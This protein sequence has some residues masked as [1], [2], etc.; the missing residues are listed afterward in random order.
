[1]ST[2]QGYP[3][4]HVKAFYSDPA[5]WVDDT[6]MDDFAWHTQKLTM[7]E[8]Q[9]KEVSSV[10]DDELVFIDAGYIITDKA[11]PAGH[12]FEGKGDVDFEQALIAWM[13]GKGLK[14][15]AR[16]LF[17]VRIDT[18]KLSVQDLIAFL[19]SKDAEASVVDGV[20]WKVI[21]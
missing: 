12:L 6:Y 10:G 3:G 20:N 16:Q 21:S 14:T 17:H 8:C 4:R 11:F 5:F 1:M 19:R 13:Q 2:Q 18:D 15:G 7:E 9:E